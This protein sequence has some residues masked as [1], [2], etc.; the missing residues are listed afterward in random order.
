MFKIYAVTNRKLCKTDF[1]EQIE[2]L[3]RHPS[4]SSIVLR[5]KD[6]SEDEYLRLAEKIAPI[7]EQYGQELILHTFINAAE[8]IN[9]LN[10]HL[11][12]SDLIK[13]KDVLSRFKTVGTSVHSAE[14][15]QIA[16][17]CKV[18][19][20][21]AGHIFKTDCKPDIAPRGIKFLTSAVRLSNA[22]V[23]A[24]GGINSKNIESVRQAGAAGACIMS[25]SMQENFEI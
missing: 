13:Y 11:S 23:Y 9:C 5:E 22:P 4:I 16:N 24:I 8:K 12:I 1:R 17:D 25:L 2:R 21:F 7:C 10:I 20:V 3:C 19:Y 18:S 6:L 15:I 14:Q